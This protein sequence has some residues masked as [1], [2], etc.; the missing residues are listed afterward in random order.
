[1]HCWRALGELWKGDVLASDRSEDARKLRRLEHRRPQA[2]E[3]LGVLWR[4]MGYVACEDLTR[5][6]NGLDEIE[7]LAS[8]SLTWEPTAIWARAEYE[9]IRGGGEAALAYA[10][11]ALRRI[12]P[13]RHLLWASAT[14]TRLLILVS[15]GRQ[16]EA[17]RDGEQSL[18]AG[19]EVGLD[20]Q[21]ASLH[22]ATA[23]AT[24]KQGD[25]PGA[26]GHVDSALAI[27]AEHQ[28]G[29]MRLGLAFETA[30]SVAIYLR[31]AEAFER[32][33]PCCRELYHAHENRALSTKY[34]RLIRTATRVGLIARSESSP[35][36]APAIHGEAITKLNGLL[37]T[38]ADPV[39]A[40]KRTLELIAESV[41]A[42]AGHVFTLVDDEPVA[43]AHF[44]GEAASAEM[45]EAARSQL[46]SERD[47]SDET[48]DAGDGSQMSGASHAYQSVLIG[49]H[50]GDTFV[51]HGLAL[52]L[53]A[54]P[55]PEE[56]RQLARRLSEYLESAGALDHTSR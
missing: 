18:A 21:L 6:R 11:D 46:L 16:A 22:L 32:F 40:I 39:T 15:L 43:W 23:L 31:D 28:A 8:R 53:G 25:A 51:T 35:A 7:R 13:G 2:Y 1:M 20:H 47:E 4:F 10:D 48:Q 55:I 38:C 12:Q 3:G 52:L 45:T 5:M 33:A 26:W 30:T 41:G 27:L 9:R 19:R 44:G 34:D 36:H 29:G 56:T 49:H 17:Q 54:E 37:E 24:A 50:S 42:R 14:S